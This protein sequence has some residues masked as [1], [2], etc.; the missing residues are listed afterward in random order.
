MASFKR[1]LILIPH[2]FYIARKSIAVLVIGLLCFYIPIASADT[3]EDFFIDIRVKGIDTVS[4]IQLIAQ[5]AALNVVIGDEIKN[6]RVAI[7]EKSVGARQLITRIAGAQH[8]SI[9]PYHDILMIASDCRLEKNIEPPKQ[10]RYLEKLS[11]NFQYATASVIVND[12]LP[13]SA[14]AYFDTE[15]ID[16]TARLTLSGNDKSISD[17]IVAVATV[18][19]WEV[20]P[21]N[22]SGMRL[23][24]NDQVKNCASSSTSSSQIVG[25]V[26]DPKFPMP[27]PPCPFSDD[28]GHECEMLERYD[29]ESLKFLG[30]MKLKN[31]NKRFAFVENQ[32]GGTFLVQVGLRVGKNFGQIKAITDTEVK[33]TEIVQDANGT[34]IEKAV[35]IPFT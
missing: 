4:V 25:R 24:P 29:L 5:Q 13:F 8:L 17:Y 14:R 2:M 21:L 30:Y 10:K 26:P 11:L 12:I 32:E 33:I 23:I 7:N 18:E 1:E 6:D 3:A 19:G 9:R 35:T 16:K 31:K 15:S 22:D 20:Q 34:W 28:T 27:L